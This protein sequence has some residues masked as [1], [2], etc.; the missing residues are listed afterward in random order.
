VG[1]AGASEDKPTDED[2]E[3]GAEDDD[4][5]AVFLDLEVDD[6]EIRTCGETM[7]EGFRRCNPLDAV[8]G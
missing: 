7:G 3:E 2:S 8:A 1:G 4:G 5:G 6:T